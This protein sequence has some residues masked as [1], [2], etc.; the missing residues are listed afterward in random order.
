MPCGVAQVNPPAGIRTYVRLPDAPARFGRMADAEDE[1]AGPDREYVQAVERVFA[2]ILA[3]DRDRPS[4]TLSEVGRATGLTR[5]TARRFLLTLQRLGYVSCEDHRFA[6]TPR[7]L[8]LGHAFLASNS[9]WD[10]VHDHLE[11]L[12]T[13][14]DDSS[15]AAVLDGADILYVVRVPRKRVFS[16]AVEVGTRLPAHATSLGRVMLA[17]LG[18]DEL[19][20]YLGSVALVPFTQRTVTDPGALRAQL[21]VVR[22]QGWCVLDQELE[23]GLRSVAVP[24]RDRRGRVFA[25]ANVATATARVTLDRLRRS[26]LPALLRT[27]EAIERDVARVSTP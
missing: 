24:L 6:L 22:E 2:V 15:S 18:E 3:F 20:H 21:K 11:R 12:V 26:H 4:L 1:E 14:V 23:I 16:S 13:E 19:D 7:L 5:G 10:V 8:D 17:H 9:C 25:A 27:A